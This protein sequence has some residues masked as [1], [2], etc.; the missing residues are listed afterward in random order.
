MS[1]VEYVFLTHKDFP[2]HPF[3]DTLK[4]IEWLLR[5]LSMPVRVDTLNEKPSFE[6]AHRGP[7]RRLGARVRVNPPTGIWVPDWAASICIICLWRAYTSAKSDAS[8]KRALETMEAGLD[9]PPE[10]QELMGLLSLFRL[11][12]QDKAWKRMRFLVRKARERAGVQHFKV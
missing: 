9:T 3:Q 2:R 6:Y 4:K 12:Q 7:G 1:K 5:D 10:R 11:G 8:W